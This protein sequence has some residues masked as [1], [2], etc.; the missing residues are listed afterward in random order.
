MSESVADIPEAPGAGQDQECAFCG[1]PY[2]AHKLQEASGDMFHEWAHHGSALREVRR[3][4][5][6]TPLSN[7]PII[8]APA[9]DIL[10][11][12]L[13]RDKGLITPD[14]YRSL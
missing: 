7:T 12:Q 11:R 9:P 14:E 13:L 10:L 3:S 1:T 5:G 4:E 8:V 2:T 6:N